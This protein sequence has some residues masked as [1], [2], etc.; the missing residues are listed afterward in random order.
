MNRAVHLLHFADRALE[1]ALPLT[2]EET[3]RRH[4]QKI[5]A[6]AAAAIRAARAVADDPQPDSPGQV[7]AL[8][9]GAELLANFANLLHAEAGRVGALE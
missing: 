4:A 5:G 2:A 6:A 3:L 1:I 7:Y 8:L 9:V